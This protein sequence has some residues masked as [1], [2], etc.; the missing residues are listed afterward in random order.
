MDEEEKAKARAER[1]RLQK[2]ADDLR[3]FLDEADI[4]MKELDA[5]ARESD[6][7]WE[8]LKR[9]NDRVI[10]RSQEVREMLANSGGSRM[11]L[12]IWFTGKCD[13]CGKER[14]IARPKGGAFGG[15]GPKWCAACLARAG[16]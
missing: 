11:K 2:V 4:K 9:E 5:Q 6:K 7:K 8:E 10:A 16:R 14:D 1:E 3:S 15:F 13:K 12:R